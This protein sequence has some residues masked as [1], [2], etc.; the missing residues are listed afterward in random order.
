MVVTTT[1]RKGSTA[2][3]PAP[4]A[5][6]PAPKQSTKAADAATAS[7]KGSSDDKVKSALNSLPGAKTAE[8][9]MRNAAQIQARAAINQAAQAKAVTTTTGEHYEGSLA[10]DGKRHGQGTLT[11][12]NGNQY[13]GEWVQGRMTGQAIFTYGGQG[14]D[15]YEGSFLNDKKHGPGQYVF[16]NGNTYVGNF[17]NDKRHGHGEYRWV[18]GDTYVGDWHEGKMHGK[19][20]TTYA[21]GNQYEGYFKEDRRDG[22]GKLVCVDGLTFDGMWK[23]NMRNGEGVLTFPNGDKYVGGWLDDQK[24]GKGKDTFVNGNFFEGVYAH[25]QKS[26]Y[27]VMTFANRDIYEGEWSQDTMHGRGTYKFN[28]GYMYEGM[29]QHDLRHGHGVYK[30]NNTVYDGEWVEDKRHGKGCMTIDDG[31]ETYTGE[32]KGG[33]MD[34]KFVVAIKKPTP[35]TYEGEWKVGQPCNLGSFKFE[36]SHFVGK[37]EEHKSK[38]KGKNEILNMISEVEG[39]PPDPKITVQKDSDDREERRWNEQCLYVESLQRDQASLIQQLNLMQ[40]DKDEALR[41]REQNMELHRALKAGQLE[42]ELALDKNKQLSET[43]VAL[44]DQLQKQT[45][46]VS[47]LE[48]LIT[49]SHAQSQAFKTD[50]T[51]REKVWSEMKAELEG[52]LADKESKIEELLKQVSQVQ[53]SDVAEAGMVSQL[54]QDLKEAE[55]KLEGLKQELANT[56]GS[57]SGTQTQ[58]GDAQQELVSVKEQLASAHQQF[59][60]A[61]EDILVLQ[62]KLKSAD[63][64]AKATDAEAKAQQATANGLL[65][66]KD[67]L[68]SEL[69]KRIANLQLELSAAK[70][71]H[72]QQEEAEEVVDRR[73]QAI[74]ERDHKI[75]QLEMQINDLK[76]ENAATAGEVLTAQEWARK[77][78]EDA[79]AAQAKC[80]E[81][82]TLAGPSKQHIAALEER[83]A[84]L[85][86]QLRQAND[87]PAQS[88]RKTSIGPTV[89]EIELERQL[90]LLQQ[91]LEDAEEENRK[92]MEDMKPQ[93][94]I[95]E[96]LREAK[97]DAEADYRVAKQTISGLKEELSSEKKRR[98]R[99]EKLLNSGEDQSAESYK[100]QVV[101]LRSELERKTAEIAGLHSQLDTHDQYSKQHDSRFQGHS[102]SDPESDGRVQMLERKVAEL[103]KKM[104]EKDQILKYQAEEI[105]KVTQLQA[106][107]QVARDKLEVMNASSEVNGIKEMTRL[108]SAQSQFDNRRLLSLDHDQRNVELQ[109]EML[110]RTNNHNRMLDNR[111]SSFTQSSFSSSFGPPKPT[112]PTRPQGPPSGK[113]VSRGSRKPE[114]D[115]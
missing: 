69:E 57:V 110:S 76:Q 6:K 55:A 22:H 13:K 109:R 83:V 54:Q 56:Q 63:A 44:Q 20:V 106:Q 100:N 18:C 64:E 24:H 96:S 21:N 1:A 61:Q 67:T 27:G 80:Q 30:Y 70:S 102:S 113:P 53:A 71:Q 33:K 101:I 90:A 86:E 107:L 81:L 91:A 8:E 46:S 47:K 31:V 32:W 14:G 95:L 39:E 103:L 87:R 16:A 7:K 92:K 48:E 115:L 99:A 3:K 97:S 4:S 68:L 10:D 17:E 50:L 28:N 9:V 2:K 23:N 5:K 37:W 66:E 52:N 114:L 34:G 11:W 98:K 108:L 38:S 36:N 19:G 26:G 25:N 65:R 35:C 45:A 104:E 105:R 43:L 112:P 51:D 41:Q 49:T 84:D 12:A 60:G 77:M 85:N 111:S 73:N 79:L 94:V 93:L 82:E 59:T 42:L 89:R 40:E 72:A 78:K 15:V 62:N 74:R 88:T 58:L 75:S 29:W